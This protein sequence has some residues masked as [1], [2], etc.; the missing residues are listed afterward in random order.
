MLRITTVHPDKNIQFRL[1]DGRGITL[2]HGQDPREFE[3]EVMPRGILKILSNEGSG[4]KVEALSDDAR[5]LLA[6]ARKIPKRVI[7]TGV[8]GSGERHTM[9]EVMERERGQ[10]MRV[11]DD[12]THHALREARAKAEAEQADID[13]RAAAEAAEK[14]AREG[15]EAAKREAAM[16]DQTVRPPVDQSDPRYRLLEKAETMEFQELRRVAKELLRDDF[17]SGTVKREDVIKA[18]QDSFKKDN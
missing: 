12:F 5:A 4:F 3:P 8:H 16:S 1:T 17:P 11:R 14:A 2:A 15:I 13:S 10:G 9:E 6:E 18:L 7:F